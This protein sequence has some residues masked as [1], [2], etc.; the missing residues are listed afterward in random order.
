MDGQ[1][2]HLY[3]LDQANSKVRA[4]RDRLCGWASEKPA[5]ASASQAP[6]IRR[7][8]CMPTHFASVAHFLSIPK[9]SKKISSGLW[10]SMQG[11]VVAVVGKYL[12]PYGLFR[13]RS[14]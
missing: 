13:G 2:G 9:G 8:S 11:I 4:T 12:D 10:D 7:T 6:G 1:G 14:P 3:S 5:L